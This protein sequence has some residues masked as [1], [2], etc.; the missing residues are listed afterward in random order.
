LRCKPLYI[1]G[2]EQVLSL[3]AIR[4]QK[5]TLSR[6]ISDAQAQLA[7]LDV[8]E[9]IVVRFGQAVGDARPSDNEIDDL[10]GGVTPNQTALVATSIGGR[11]MTTKALM[12]AVLRQSPSPWMTSEELRE[13]VSALK[14]EEVPMGTV[15]PTLSNLKNDG[16]ILRDGFKIALVE[17]LN[18]NGLRSDSLPR[19]PETALGAH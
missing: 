10:L 3:T 14:G 5:A 12:Q 18:E 16:V 7:D 6:T 1:S 8:A 15:G 2:M 11:A 17:R 19:S 4:A 9:R 13:R